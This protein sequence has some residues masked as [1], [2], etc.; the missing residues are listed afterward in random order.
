M[1]ILVY[2]TI[3]L[4]FCTL[5]LSAQISASIKGK[6]VNGIS[7]KEVKGVSVKIIDT[8]ID[9]KTNEFG[10]F[11]LNNISTGNYIIEIFFIGF[12]NQKIPIHISEEKEYDIGIIYLQ[13]LIEEIHESSIILLSDDD[14]LDDG[15]RSSDNIAGLFQSSKDAYLRAA[16]FNF[17]QAWF[18]VRGYDSSYGVISI[19]G[20]EMNK[21]YDGR[22]QWGNWGGL[23]DVFRNQEFSN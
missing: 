1:R 12:E 7:E 4:F 3:V 8:F 15:E 11:K 16:A 14:L 13:Q 18:K 17:S 2:T 23:N 5:N 22:P 10:D 19:N 21:L 6:V 20:I 9:D